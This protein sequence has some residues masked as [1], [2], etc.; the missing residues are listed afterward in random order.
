MISKQSA[1]KRLGLL[2]DVYQFARHFKFR[3]D[4]MEACC[5]KI[6]YF[7]KYIREAFNVSSAEFSYCRTVCTMDEFKMRSRC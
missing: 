7:V 2:D 4:E 5:K 6:S 1:G 3:L